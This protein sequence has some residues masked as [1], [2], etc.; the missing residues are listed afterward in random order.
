MPKPIRQTAT[1]KNI[2]AINRNIRQI[3][4]VFGTNS[5]QY[6]IA[7]NEIGLFQMY[8]KNG[9]LQIR[10][11]AENRKQ[12]QKIRSMNK[13][14]LN[15]KKEKAKVQKQIDKY[16][17]NP[18]TQ[19][20]IRTIKAFTQLQQTL[21]EKYETVYDMT[22]FIINYAQEHPELDTVYD[23]DSTAHRLFSDTD[24]YDEMKIMIEEMKREEETPETVYNTTLGRKQTTTQVIN[25]QVVVIDD[26][27]GEV[28]DVFDEFFL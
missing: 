25:G 3:A 21:E 23:R 5:A 1:Y 14:K 15:I 9:V 20:K 24:Y 18:R 8:T 19:D 16:N 12:H 26:N 13:R 10:N 6:E 2:N 17:N 22:D 11:T 28:I 27:T 7:T 4:E